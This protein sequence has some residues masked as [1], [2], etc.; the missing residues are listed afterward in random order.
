[1]VSLMKALSKSFFILFWAIDNYKMEHW[2]MRTG[3]LG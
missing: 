3:N 1:M 2:Y